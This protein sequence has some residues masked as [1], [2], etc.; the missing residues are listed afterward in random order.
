MI[1]E[2]F[3]TTAELV[4][5]SGRDSQQN[6]C[7]P[8]ITIRDVPD[9]TRDELVA[10]AAATGRSLQEYLRGELIELAMRQDNEVLL[11]RIADRKRLT[12]SSMTSRQI[13]G[14]RGSGRP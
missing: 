3:P 5:R 1:E 2:L 9:E 11:A 8:A 10:R 4:A 13:L 12:G 7:V 6:A 14:H